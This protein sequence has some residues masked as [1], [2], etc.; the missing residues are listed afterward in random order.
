MILEGR[1]AFVTGG[2]K[3]IGRAI[4]I[5]LAQAGAAVALT[6]RLAGERDGTAG[7][8]AQ[9]IGGEGYRALPLICDVRDVGEI[10]AAMERTI[11]HFGRLDIL[12]NNA[13]LYFPGVDAIEQEVAQWRETIDTHIHGT[14]L[15][16]R[17]A[18]PH[19]IAAGGGSIVNLSSTAGDRAH[20]SSGNL[21]YAVA[22][23]GIEQL[24]RG[25][26]R[27]LARYDIAVNAIRPMALLSE[28]SLAHAAWLERYAA[29]YGGQA[30]Y[31]AMTDEQR[32]QR[33]SDPSAIVPAIVNLA[34][35][36]AGFTG[37]VVRRT[38]FDGARFVEVL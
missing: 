18:A 37:H 13:G 4:A 28:G 31:G 32:M 36:R 23:A 12:I 14:F 11:E 34:R 38:D 26:A 16:A 2:S 15:C 3:G 33:F 25:L 7:A 35:C 27:E 6:G 30:P 8:T 17:A 24:T 19:L 21:A 20:D 22:K 9:Q 5:G 10:E 29:R 1:V